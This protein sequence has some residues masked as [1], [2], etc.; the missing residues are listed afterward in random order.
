MKKLKLAA[1]FGND[2]VLQREKNIN[3]WGEAEYMATVT[4]CI[5][6][7]SRKTV[8]D[9][10]GQWKLSFPPMNAG[11][12]YTVT[13]SDGTDTIEFTNVMIG[14]VW[15]AGGQSNMQFELCNCKS[16]MHTRKEQ[17]KEKYNIR[18]YRTE[19]ISYFSDDFEK[20]ERKAKWRT[21]KN[22]SFYDVSA[23]AYYAAR[24]LAKKM[25]DITIGV[26]EC[27]WGGTSASTWVDKNT[28]LK[29]TTLSEYIL[30]YEKATEGQDLK[31]YK[32]QFKEFLDFNKN[33]A[34]KYK[35]LKKQNKDLT[36]QEAT[37]ILGPDR[38]C[39]PLGP[40]SQY[41]PNAL[42]GTMFSRVCPYTVRGV[43]YYQGESDDHKAHIYREL[44]TALI[45]KWRTDWNDNKLPF[46]FIQLPMYIPENCPDY[47]HWAVLREAQN[48][49]FD[50]VK[51]TGMVI[52]LDQGEFNNIHPAQKLYVGTRL[53]NLTLDMVY[54][55]ATNTLSPMYK[56]SY[57]SDNM[58]HIS[59][60]NADDG[61][62][63]PESLIAGFEI[64]GKDKKFTEAYATINGNTIS[65]YS[66]EVDEPVYVR[67]NFTNYGEVNLFGKNGL[68]V[69]PF[70]TSRDD[71]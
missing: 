41:A 65:V 8:S 36:W 33:W 19:K 48:D 25:P 18:F 46:I 56:S 62:E 38:W 29:T 5:E 13:V 4:V 2:M 10:K 40:Y 49:T 12:P 27:D 42:Y 71:F 67:Y 57:I 45:D 55:L 16:Y 30:D 24:E 11:G 47:K 6:N 28:L 23:V 9:E 15:F 50:T 51:N 21:T 34:K 63:Q 32:K 1:V 31:E 69:A 58:V 26:V 37:E 22:K 59:F 14:E 43:W 53:G 70:R 39:P 52:A 54:G 61:F 68:P 17:K 64:A 35:E 60:D 20:K 3:F 66:D 7:I 44:L